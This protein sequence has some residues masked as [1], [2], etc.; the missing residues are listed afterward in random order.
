MIMKALR[1]ILV[2]PATIAG[3]FLGYA[4]KLLID[5]FM[6]GLAHGV[7]GFYVSK[8]IAALFAGGLAIGAAVWIAPNKKKLAAIIGAVTMIAILAALTIFN[9]TY[10]NEHMT[11]AM[12][13]T[14]CTAFAALYVTIAAC[15]EEDLK[16]M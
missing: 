13:E 4:S 8:I 15:K 1:W 9:I 11:L 2:I 3:W 6:S 16:D 14:A 7:I 12:I 5:G 10:G